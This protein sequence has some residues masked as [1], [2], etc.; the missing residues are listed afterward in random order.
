M[1]KEK[2]E[3]RPG[4][5]L[6]LISI[7]LSG[8]SKNPDTD[9][10]KTGNVNQTVAVI[11][12]NTNQSPTVSKN[13][14][15]AADSSNNSTPVVGN[16]PLSVANKDKKPKPPANDPIP[17]I[18]SGGSDLLLFTQV[19]GALSS[20]NELSNAVIVEMKEGNAVLTGNVS[21]EAQKIKAAQLVQ[22]VQGIKSVKNNLRVA[23]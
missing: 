22:S 9:V 5:I 8:C 23:S 2:T 11:N 12:N 19:R 4:V 6:I 16:T 1:V 18:G 13:N 20:D 7:V 17:Q 3:I 21:S 15:A 14:S 10:A